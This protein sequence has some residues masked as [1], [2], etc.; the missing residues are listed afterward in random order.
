MAAAYSQVKRESFAAFKRRRFVPDAIRVAQME[1]E[2][3]AMSDDDNM[4]WAAAV[5]EAGHVVVA[6]ALGLQVQAISVTDS[7]EGRS[8]I[9]CTAR[10]PLCQQI[11]IAE[12]GIMAA[13]LL[14][15]PTWPRAGMADA[16]KVLELL[17]RHAVPPCK[18][19]EGRNYA[20]HVLSSRLPLL[21]DLA[22][23]L[24]H[25]GSLNV[26]DLESFAGRCLTDPHRVVRVEC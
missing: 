25:L 19:I 5:H 2:R 6:W 21:R 24:D 4:H 7:G 17:E 9:E 15:T 11:A 1:T 23:T 8:E 16:S 10:C 22:I 13:Q 12:A 18:G 26:A 20:R 3:V 14:S